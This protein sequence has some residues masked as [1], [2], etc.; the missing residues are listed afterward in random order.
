LRRIEQAWYPFSRCFLAAAAVLGA[1]VQHTGTADSLLQLAV[2]FQLFVKR[3]HLL[4]PGGR[5]RSSNFSFESSCSGGG[6]RRRVVFFHSGGFL[7]R[8]LPAGQ[9]TVQLPA[10][11][12]HGAR[13][14]HA[15][16][17]LC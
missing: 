16:L 6:R 12:L 10:G 13:S 4:S 2:G 1:R 3:G 5:L 14:L 8:F 15:A 9:V 7:A 11:S 17:S